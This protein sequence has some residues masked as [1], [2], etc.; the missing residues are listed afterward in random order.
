M[1]LP[2]EQS[3]LFCLECVEDS[4]ENNTSD[5]FPMLEQLVLQHSIVNVYKTC[6]S[7]ETFEEN[8]GIL[9]YEDRD[10]KHYDLL[11]FVCSGAENQIEIDG[12]FY[13]LEEIA[14]LFEDKLKGKIVHFANTKSLQLDSETA[15]YFLDITGAKALSGY[16]HTHHFASFVLD[17]HFFALYQ[18]INEVTELVETL[19]ENHYALCT[20]LGFEL[21][22]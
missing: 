21:Y 6:D 13:S 18:K 17:F 10:F 9:L 1:Y 12:Y 4:Q 8:L 19:Y 5:V 11:Y 3:Q 14:E 7:I 22:Y 2:N 20:T 16:K 15:Q